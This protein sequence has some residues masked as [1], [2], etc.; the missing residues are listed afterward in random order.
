M[1]IIDEKYRKALLANKVYQRIINSR[2]D[3]TLLK[4]DASEFERWIK[5]VHRKERLERKR[6]GVL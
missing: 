5:E 1:R 3:Y 6:E 4:K 2:P